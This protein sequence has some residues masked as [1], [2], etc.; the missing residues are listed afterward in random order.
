MEMRIMTRQ[1]MSS[2]F[3]THELVSALVMALAAACG[4]SGDKTPTGPPA[5]TTASITGIVRAT[6]TNGPIAGAVVTVGAVSVTTGQDGR[7]TFQNLQIATPIQ[8][9]VEA[10][11][12]DPVGLS[13]TLQSGANS[14]DIT[15]LRST[16]V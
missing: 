10:P 8:I 14:R 13:V 9:M 15:L 1:S 2:G 6:T 11:G 3:G 4:G 12:F 7:F 5:A 16:L